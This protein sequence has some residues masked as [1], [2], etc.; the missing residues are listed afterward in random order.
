MKRIL[1]GI[2]I[3][4]LATNTIYA[5]KPIEAQKKLI[6]TI[7]EKIEFT[8]YI[9]NTPEDKVFDDKFKILE[10]W[11]T[12]CKP[13]LE[14]VPHLNELQSEFKD[15]S[16]LVFLSV[17][18]ETIKKTRKVLKKINFETIVV[19]DQTKKIHNDLRIEY[20]GMMI[21]PRTVLINSSNEIIWYGRPM[22]LSKDLIV[23]FL[24]GK[25]K[26]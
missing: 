26:L 2:A 12:W 3:L 5:Q 23:N 11:A 1:L 20:Q 18:Y 21:L 25:K 16:N 19:S 13:C 15:E 10:F 6:G 17:T 22:E 8:D 24:S 9:E 14:A 7:I 4:S